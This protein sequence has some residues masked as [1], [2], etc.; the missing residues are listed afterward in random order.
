MF[1]GEKDLAGL[2]AD[3]SITRVS[4][5]QR[6]PMATDIIFREADLYRC[7]GVVGHAS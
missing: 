4:R 5:H 6:T 1:G 7:P 3:I 2:A